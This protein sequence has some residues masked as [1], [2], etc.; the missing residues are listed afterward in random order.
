MKLRDRDSLHA[1][2]QARATQTLVETNAQAAIVHAE[3]RPSDAAIAA[4]L[5]AFADWVETGNAGA[6]V[7]HALQVLPE[8]EHE[9]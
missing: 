4:E 8:S 1:L 9:G 3:E 7:V 2:L 5:R 6:S